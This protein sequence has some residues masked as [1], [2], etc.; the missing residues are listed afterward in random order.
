MY[1]PETDPQPW[2]CWHPAGGAVP[3]SWVS[4]ENSLARTAEGQ[5]R[6]PGENALK[7]IQEMFL[8]HLQHALPSRAA[9]GAEVIEDAVAACKELL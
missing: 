2:S 3:F 5:N 8:E 1:F 6:G 7:C 9:G 4:D